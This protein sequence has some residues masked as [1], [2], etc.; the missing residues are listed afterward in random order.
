METLQLMKHQLGLGAITTLSRALSA[1]I[2]GFNDKQFISDASDSIE[3]LEL[4]QRVEHLIVVLHE[5]LPI[6][7]IDAAD[8]LMKIAQQWHKDKHESSWGAFTAWPLVD[9]VAIYGLNKPELA[10]KVLRDLTPLFSAEFAIRP[11]IEQHFEL[12]HQV[13]LV[14]CLDDD[15][16]VRRLAT[17]GI[18]PRLPWAKQLPQFFADPNPIF[19]ILELLKNDSSLYVRKSVAN[20]LNDITK[21]NPDL[22]IEVCRQ[23]MND[24]SVETQWIIR[25][26]LRSLIKQG[27][28]EVFPLLGYSEQ[29]QVSLNDLKLDRSKINLGEEVTVSI[30]LES[31]SKVKQKLVVD[32]KIHHQK[33]NGQKTAKVFKWK[34]ITLAKNESIFL[35]K[36]H[37]FK[38]ITTRRYYSGEHAI[39][40]LVN[41]KSMGLIS[42]EL[43]I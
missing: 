40:L 22:V 15:E 4:K 1:T 12:T 8:V 2:D 21:D 27:R 23:W 41:G 20:N 25:H 11:F 9:Y 10:F 31:N 3:G 18:R 34:N 13:L 37:P 32:Y 39:E 36:K 28:P 38:Q 29:A 30:E 5:H 19:A 35:T 24:A 26:G 7:F 6:N 42:F 16:H 14:W 43:V 33:A 17:E